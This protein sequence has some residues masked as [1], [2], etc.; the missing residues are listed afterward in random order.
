MIIEHGWGSIILAERV[1][2]N[3]TIH[4]NCTIGWNHGGKPVI[5]DNVKMY[6]GSV[7]AGPIKV[8]ND[9]TIGAN[10]VVVIDVPDNSVC[11]GNP[12][13]IKINN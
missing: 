1:G 5:G 13:K 7:I 6:P 9:V 11:V 3:F 12:C 4:Q 10:C 2:K 8:G